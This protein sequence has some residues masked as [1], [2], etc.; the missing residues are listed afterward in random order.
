MKNWKT[1]LCGLGIAAITAVQAYNG[2]DWKGYI[3]AALVA[4][5]GVLVKDFNK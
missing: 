3:G 4:A 5:F 2:H 1:T